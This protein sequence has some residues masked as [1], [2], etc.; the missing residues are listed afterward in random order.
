MY[1]KPGTMIYRISDLSKVWVEAHIYEYELPWVTQ[2][3]EA[4]MSLPYQPGKMFSGTVSYVYPYLQPKTRDVVVRL[5]FDNPDLLLKPDM[6]ANVRINTATGREGLVIPSEA[7]IR[8]GER[9]V[10]FVT[11]DENKFV[12][13]NVT[14]GLSLDNGMVQVL[15]GLAPG[16]TIVTS[17][18]FLIDSESNLKEAVQKMLEIKRAKSKAKMEDMKEPIK[19]VDEDVLEDTETE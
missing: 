6:Y 13:R 11:R 15:E 2:G 5:E 3:L 19:E 12:P 7:V 10:V 16:E 18:Q 9:N 8:S 1:V 4:E 14:L 17:G